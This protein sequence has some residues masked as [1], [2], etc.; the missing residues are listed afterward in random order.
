MGLR[1]SFSVIDDLGFPEFRMRGKTL[2]KIDYSEG[3][4]VFADTFLSYA[5]NAVPVDTG[6]LRSTI[7]ADSGEDSCICEA[8]CEY[9]EYVEYGTS[10][11]GAQEFFEPAVMAGLT[12]AIPILSN[13]QQEAWHGELAPYFV[14]IP[15]T[16]IG[17]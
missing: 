9:A 15:D 4:H 3:C 14:T 8:D 16:E 12:A 11:M 7:T 5:L 6:Y 17:K 1:V 13:I 10:K 2:E